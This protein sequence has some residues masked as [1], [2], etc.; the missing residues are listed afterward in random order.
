MSRSAKVLLG[1]AFA[2]YPLLVYLMIDRVGPGA[3]VSILAVLLF[4]RL[5]LL[6]GRPLL[7]LY[8]AAVIATFCALAYLNEDL[9]VLKLYPVIVSVTLGSLCVYTLAVPPSAI[10]RLMKAIGTEVSPQAIRYTRILTGIWAVFFV[11]NAS[12]AGYTALIAPTGVWALY[13][14]IISYG[15]IGLLIVLEYPVRWA[16]KKRHSIVEVAAA[17]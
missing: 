6:K 15:L 4:A 17:P 7:L 11:F 8:G 5:A 13:N 16:Y 2:L 10:E 12:M 3:I 14:G 1:I 9:T